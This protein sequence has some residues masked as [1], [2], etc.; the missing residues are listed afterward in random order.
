MSSTSA[1]NIIPG[2]KELL[3]ETQEK[4]Q[5]LIGKPVSVHYEIRKHESSLLDLMDMVSAVGGVSVEE[6]KGHTRERRVLVW[7]QVYCWYGYHWCKRTLK[8][9]G[10]SINRDHTTVITAID[11]VNNMIDTNDELYTMPME[12]VK[13]KIIAK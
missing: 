13:E 3:D 4:I 9:V 1:I 5:S 12:A 7:R 11:R 2:L 8:E 6:I 10:V